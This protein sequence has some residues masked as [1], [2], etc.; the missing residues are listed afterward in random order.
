MVLALLLAAGTGLYLAGRPNPQELACNQALTQSAAKLASDDTAGARSQALLAVAVCRGESGAKASDLQAAV[1]K[2]LAAK[3]GCKLSLRRVA[4]QIAEHQLQSARAA[5]DKLDP[6]CGDSPQGKELRTQIGAGQNAANAAEAEVRK[7]L[8]EGDGIGAL[9]SLE[10]VS[11]H[12]REHPDLAVMR[13]SLESLA[14]YTPPVVSPASAPDPLPTRAEPAP[15][16][17]PLPTAKPLPDAVA[18]RP[19]QVIRPTVAQASAV[20]PLPTANPLPSA[21]S[22]RP[23]PALNPQTELLHTFLREAETA[24]RQL[25][26]DSAKTYVDSA[27]RIEP[28]NVQATALARRISERELQ[29]LR[30]ETS[31][32]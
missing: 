17:T 14:R 9:V 5:L 16:V 10:Q 32:K 19:A 4:S 25:K 1:D 29:Y 22:T 20:T 13:Q 28:G 6:A 27:R 12:N 18:I 30:D 3:S 7:Q 2:A 15:A 24:L 8:A 21:V 23:A 26:F 31:I 11:A